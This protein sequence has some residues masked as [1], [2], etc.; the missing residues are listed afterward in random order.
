MYHVQEKQLC[1]NEQQLGSASS[2]F[3]DSKELSH[4][5]EGDG[6]VHLPMPGRVDIAFVS[7]TR[8]VLCESKRPSDLVT[9]VLNHR[10]ARQVKALTAMSQESGLVAVILRG[11]LPSFNDSNH[12]AILENLVA[13]QLLGVI[14]LPLPVS[15]KRAVEA[16]AS[17]REML[18]EGS[19]RALVAVAGT[20][21]PSSAPS[22]LQSVKGIGAAT[23]AKLRRT[24]G[25]SALDVLNAGGDTWEKV[26]VSKLIVKRLSEACV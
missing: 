10:L 4:M 26:G 8:V 16:L 9:S 23:E 5:G 18:T 25:P 11:A 14:L 1:F 3:A 21:K 20:D 12:T 6:V 13:L 24:C 7:G 22:L 19:R 15:D 17:Y 2:L